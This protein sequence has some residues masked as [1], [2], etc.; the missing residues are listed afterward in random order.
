MIVII[1]EIKIW[2]FLWNCLLRIEGR[3]RWADSELVINFSVFHFY[4]KEEILLNC[5][6]KYSNRKTV[7][8]IWKL[9]GEARSLKR[10]RKRQKGLKLRKKMLK[11]QRRHSNS[12]SKNILFKCTCVYLCLLFIQI[13]LLLLNCCYNGWVNK[14][15]VKVT[16]IE[17]GVQTCLPIWDTK[18]KLFRIVNVFCTRP[19][20][21]IWL[22]AP[23]IG[24]SWVKWTENKMQH[25]S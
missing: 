13:V 14:W 8:A 21:I 2:L 10:E 18:Y 20:F 6:V 7:T 15:K 1:I 17:H 3:K 16:Y 22:E 9:K 12:E 5:R 25:R 4:F 11:I 19:L 24:L 23:C